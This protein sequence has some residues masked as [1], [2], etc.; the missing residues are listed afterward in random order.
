MGILILGPMAL[1]YGS[2]LC[3]RVLSLANSDWPPANSRICRDPTASTLLH[4]TAQQ[5]NGGILCSDSPMLFPPL[6]SLY[7]ARVPPRSFRSPAL[8]PKIPITLQIHFRNMA[9][10]EQKPAPWH[11][12]FPAPVSKATFVTREET[13]K[14]FEAKTAGKDFILVDVRRTDFE[15]TPAFCLLLFRSY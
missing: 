12:A 13:R 2:Q 15:V 6:R 8:S 5:T 3:A 9:T 14:L 11:A 10:T 1:F 4:P 7:K